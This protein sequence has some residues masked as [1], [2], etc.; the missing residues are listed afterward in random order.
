MTALRFTPTLLAIALVL[1]TACRPRLDPATLPEAT[2][3]PPATTPITV[4]WIETA[5][6]GPATASALLVRHPEGDLLLD[7]GSSTHFDE[8]ITAYDP[9]TRRWLRSRPGLLVPK[10]PISKRLE[11]LGIDPAALRWFLPTHA[12]IDHVGGYLD[13]PPTDVLMHP[14]EIELVRRASQ[15]TMFEV[16]PAHARALSGHL[17]PLELSEQRY[18]IFEQHADLFGDGSVVVV[19]LAGHTPGSIAVFVTLPDGRRI[20]HV[21]DAVNNRREIEHALGKH[22]S[23]Q[24]TDSDAGAAKRRVAELHALAAREPD[25]T[26]LPAH[27][28]RAY[29]DTFGQPATQC[30]APARPKPR[31]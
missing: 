16:V 13:L 5:K 25:L 20:L 22:P 10:T 28:R 12:H 26:M 2:E 29:V 1:L 9:K 23:M 30:P 19:P 11:D 17:V 18:S 31:S 3:P 15:T 7:A 27:D 24:R 14:A 6:F 4:C 8:E 21:G